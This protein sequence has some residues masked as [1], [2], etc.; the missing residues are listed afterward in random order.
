MIS[1][2]DEEVTVTYKLTNLLN[3]QFVLVFNTEPDGPL[4]SPP[5]YNI[6]VPMEITMASSTD[7][8]KHLKKL[9]TNKS[10]RSDNVHPRLLKE[11]TKLTAHPLTRIFQASL[12]TRELPVDWKV[13]NMT[14]VFKK[15]DC[16]KYEN[17]WPISLTQLLIKNIVNDSLLKHSTKNKILSPKQQGF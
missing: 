11:I 16:A 13:A 1:E 14:P 7:V 2:Q 6:K 4:S 17:C 9:N 12:I 3:Q 10:P 15:D 5:N 8:L